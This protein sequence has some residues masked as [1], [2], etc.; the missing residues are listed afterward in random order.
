MKAKVSAYIREHDLLQADGKV[1]VGI[2]GGADSMCLLLLLKEL[3][4]DLFAVHV[5]HG[6][7]GAAAEA[8]E[9]FVRAACARL[10]VPLTVAAADVPA[11]SRERGTTLEETGRDVRLSV[12]RAEAARIGCQAVAVAHHR[13][14]QAETVLL[15]MLRG[16]GPEGLTGLRASRPLSAE[17]PEGPRLIRPLLCVSKQ[18]ILDWMRS[19]GETWCEDDTNTETDADRNRVRLEVLPLL[20]RIRP[21]AGGRLAGLAERTDA[22][23][24]LAERMAETVYER[25]MCSDPKSTCGGNGMPCLNAELLQKADPAL[26]PYVLRRALAEARGSIKDITAAHLAALEGLVR[27]AD[28]GA[29]DLPGI[30]ARRRGGF[31]L[32]GTDDPA[33]GPGSPDWTGASGE[34]GSTMLQP[35]PHVE[36]S[37]R[38]I[39]PGE[40]YPEN[41]YTKWF[42]Y[43]K[44]TQIA[45]IRRRL[46][47]DFL[48]VNGG[49]RKLL[50]R[51]FIDE[52]IPADRRANVPLL[53]DGDHIMWIIGGRN[54]GGRI[55]DR[56]KVGPETRRIL[57]AR[58]TE[59]QSVPAAGGDP[60][61]AVKEK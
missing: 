22:L 26:L 4:A 31:L 34:G 9:A 37:V 32:F 17:D 15:N 14:D 35:L 13:D 38:D 40:K 61:S 12:F 23:T 48:E 56:Y 7:R 43:D 16:C 55:S 20:E 36:L 27:R 44:I 10:Q 41:P 49:E 60:T 18:E 50:R 53:A 54:P 47:G 52:K 11:L 57:E 5:N 39:A 2:S 42:D 24:G 33:A 29:A 1:L 19:R 21:G 46:P 3:G 28:D 45:V 59:H 30:R 25:A 6:I 51:W 8:D 58:L